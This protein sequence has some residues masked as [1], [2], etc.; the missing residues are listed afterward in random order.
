MH[1]QESMADICQ[2]DGLACHG[3][4]WLPALFCSAPAPSPATSN[5]C[6]THSAVPCKASVLFEW[7]GRSGVRCTHLLPWRTRHTH[8]RDHRQATAC[9]SNRAMDFLF[10]ASQRREIKNMQ[11]NTACH[12]TSGWAHAP[13]GKTPLTKSAIPV[14]DLFP[15]PI[16][17]RHSI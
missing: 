4:G 15:P 14:K 13:L 2:P 8:G 12:C 17:K 5:R 3:H 11:A 10:Q 7:N 16:S 6:I 1:A 9:I